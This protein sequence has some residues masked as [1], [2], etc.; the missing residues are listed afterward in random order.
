[1]VPAHYAQKTTFSARR[2]QWKKL[3]AKTRAS[4]RGTGASSSRGTAKAMWVCGA[5]ATAAA[6]A[7]T[8]QVGLPRRTRA[9]EIRKKAKT[10]AY[11]LHER[12]G[13]RHIRT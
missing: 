11:K 7:T 2:V 9:L 10:I 12:D 5:A 1:M 4:T 3:Q 13:P 8:D 6:F